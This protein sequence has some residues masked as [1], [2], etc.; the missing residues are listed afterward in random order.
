ML[1]HPSALQQNKQAC[2]CSTT[3]EY[4]FLLVKKLQDN[5]DRKC[6]TWEIFLTAIYKNISA[7]FV[8]LHL[9]HTWRFNESS[10]DTSV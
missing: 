5:L 2:V 6:E 1:E 4:F 7:L 8:C 10:D 9:H 3:Q